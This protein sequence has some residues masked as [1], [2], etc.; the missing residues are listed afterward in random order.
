MRT[1]SLKPGMDSRWGRNIRS[2]AAQLQ[3]RLRGQNLRRNRNRRCGHR[4]T[5]TR[6][7]RH[8]RRPLME[9][10]DGQRFLGKTRI[11]ANKVNSKIRINNCQRFMKYDS[12]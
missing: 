5:D 4:I 8:R 7:R 2:L 12:C 1:H 3:D 9:S 6:A 10:K 11:A